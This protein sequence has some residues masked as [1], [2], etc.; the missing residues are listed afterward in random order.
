MA[1][2]LKD[3]LNEIEMQFQITSE[4]LERIM[5]CMYRIKDGFEN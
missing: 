1:A 5:S 4:S 2:D 3:Q